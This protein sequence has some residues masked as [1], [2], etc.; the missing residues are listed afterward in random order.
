MSEQVPNPGVGGSYLFDPETGELTLI[1][2]NP[3]PEDNGTNSQKV[4]DRKRG[5]K[6]R[7]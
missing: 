1:K 2:A 7:E 3:T 4:S 6:L 5:G